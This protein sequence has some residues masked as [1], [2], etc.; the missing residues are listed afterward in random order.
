MARG[1][2]YDSPVSGQWHFSKITCFNLIFVVSDGG[3]IKDACWECDLFG[4][5]GLCRCN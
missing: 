1:R 4:K 2:S 5:K 3:P